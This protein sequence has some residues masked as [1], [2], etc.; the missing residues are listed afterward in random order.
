M[1]S[2]GGNRP[3]TG[4]I[5]TSTSPVHPPPPHPPV[6]QRIAGAS[7]SR[8][9]FATRARLRAAGSQWP[10]PQLPPPPCQPRRFRPE[11]VDVGAALLPRLRQL[12]PWAARRWAEC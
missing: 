2:S 9:T 1:L 3:F 12:P 6:A 7:P 5:S 10:A 8:T 4:C 11:E